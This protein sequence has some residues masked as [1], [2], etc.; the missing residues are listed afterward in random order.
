M[1]PRSLDTDVWSSHALGQVCTLVS[2]VTMESATLIEAALASFCATY[3]RWTYQ[4]ENT[5]LP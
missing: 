1:I 4:V 2:A 5:T 3:Y